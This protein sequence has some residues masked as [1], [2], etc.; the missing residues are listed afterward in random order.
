MLGWVTCPPEVSPLT[1]ALPPNRQPGPRASGPCR[2]MEGLL[3]EGGA[4]GP[5]TLQA[6][7]SPDDCQA[8]AVGARREPSALTCPHPAT[9]PRDP[10]PEGV[11]SHTPKQPS[12]SSD[13]DPGDPRGTASLPAPTPPFRGL[14][15]PYLPAARRSQFTTCPESPGPLLREPSLTWR[16][17]IQR[18]V[19][20]FTDEETEAGEQKNVPQSQ[21]WSFPRA[22]THSEVWLQGPPPHHWFSAAPVCVPRS[23]PAVPGELGTDAE[24]PCLRTTSTRPRQTETH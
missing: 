20:H 2:C 14:A 6:C 7:W 11:L 3:G 13:D 19:A 1:A 8:G 17:W 16:D 23:S 22:G 18:E 21:N 24:R 9:P 10:P 4:P 15:P 5:H 12:A